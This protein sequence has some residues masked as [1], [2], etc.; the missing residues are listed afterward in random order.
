VLGIN[1][2]PSLFDGI[3]VPFSAQA[4]L[5]QLVAAM[6]GDVETQSRAMVEA[7][8]D[9]GQQLLAL[10]ELFLGHRSHQSARY[11]VDVAAA[12][13]HQSS[14][15][16]IVA[17]GTGATGWARSINRSRKDALLLPAP[18]D[19]QLAFYVREA[20]PSNA[21]GTSISSGLITDQEQ[22]RVRS[23]MNEGG[24]IFGDGIEA[25]YLE[26]NWGVQA[27]I[28]VAQQTLELVMPARAGTQ[29]DGYESRR[30]VLQT[31]PDLL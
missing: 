4:A 28:R 25:D 3:L 16:M 10:N 11:R 29:A 7:T 12:H 22:L 30:R 23:E 5:R 24:V 14:S 27:G 20:F 1:P 15:G 17:T 19:R 6:H 8:L 31:D 13:E 21:T 18:E 9:T 26:F 2:D